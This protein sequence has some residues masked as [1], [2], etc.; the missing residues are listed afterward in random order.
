MRVSAAPPGDP[1][2]AIGPCSPRSPCCMRP[3][4]NGCP[5][6][7]STRAGAQLAVPFT[8]CSGQERLEA[9]KWRRSASGAETY[10]VYHN[11]LVPKRI[12]VVTN[13]PEWQIVD[14]AL[15]AYSKVGV[16]L[17]DTL[18]KDAVGK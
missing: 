10:Q 13:S 7:K 14:L 1:S 11:D 6:P 2:L 9:V 16:S 5:G 17:Y 15:H 12:D 18:G 8:T 4:M 3:A